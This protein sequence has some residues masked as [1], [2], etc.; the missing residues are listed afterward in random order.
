MKKKLLLSL[1]AL[2]GLVVLVVPVS[3]F[4]DA[5]SLRVH[6]VESLKSVEAVTLPDPRTNRYR[7]QISE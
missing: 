4:G 7:R 1:L 6:V 5:T 3:S 2:S